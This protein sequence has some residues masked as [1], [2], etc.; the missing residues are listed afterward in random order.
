MAQTDF[1]RRQ[2]HAFEHHH[3]LLVPL[4]SGRMMDA[5]L[6]GLQT[7]F[8]E[9]KEFERGSVMKI[10]EVL[11]KNLVNNS[12]V[13]KENVMVSNKSDASA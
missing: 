2:Y 13:K 9:F 6:T 5:R 4:Y 12:S 8:K 10:F 1:I 7:Q 11:R 3:Q